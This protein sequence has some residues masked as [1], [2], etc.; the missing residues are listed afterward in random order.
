MVNITV[1]IIPEENKSSNKEILK[2]KSKPK[3]INKI[4]EIK[5]VK[6]QKDKQKRTIDLIKF[7]EVLFDGE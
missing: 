7:F 4:L 2:F 3:M 6:K 5:K 1:K